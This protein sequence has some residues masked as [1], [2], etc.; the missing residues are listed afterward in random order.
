V[1]FLRKCGIDCFEL[2]ANNDRKY[3]EIDFFYMARG[4]HT[5]SATN[6]QGKDQ[7]AKK[8]FQD[9]KNSQ[10]IN[11]F[12]QEIQQPTLTCIT[13]HNTINKI[14]LMTSFCKLKIMLFS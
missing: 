13:F 1:K 10:S 12:F 2:D 7:E 5:T 6:S 8:N 4:I 3:F 14:A 11:E 9:S